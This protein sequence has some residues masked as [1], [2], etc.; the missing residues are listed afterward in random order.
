M[1][2]VNQPSLSKEYYSIDLI[3]EVKNRINFNS[4]GNKK[5]IVLTG[6]YIASYALPEKWIQL[7]E[8]R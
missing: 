6:E 3:E 8:P 1:G 7:M 4:L 2:L 5:R